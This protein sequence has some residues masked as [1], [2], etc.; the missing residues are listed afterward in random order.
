MRLS[1]RLQ[2]EGIGNVDRIKASA[3][4]GAPRLKPPLSTQN[5]EDHM[6]FRVAFLLIPI[7]TFAQ[8]SVDV[9]YLLDGSII[10]GSIIEQTPNQSLK[11]Q[12]G[13]NLFVIQMDKIEKIK[14]EST[15]INQGVLQGSE[16]DN[17]SPLKTGATLLSGSINYSKVTYD[18][19]DIGSVTSF[20][21]S[22]GYFFSKS[23]CLNVGFLHSSQIQKYDDIKNTYSSTGFNVGLRFYQDLSANFAYAGAQYVTL[24]RRMKWEEDG[25][26]DESDSYTD[27]YVFFEVGIMQKINRYVYFDIGANY[28]NGMGDN[29][30]GTLSFG[31]GLATFIK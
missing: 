8:E 27:N 31:I 4:P 20:E 25:Y 22:I 15:G 30:S 26:D 28:L 10:R 3:A 12:S 1:R 2:S 17:D 16:S 11:I 9:V 18:G 7:L 29:K 24:T 23:T 19:K 13:A 14:R 21:P 6:N 5:L